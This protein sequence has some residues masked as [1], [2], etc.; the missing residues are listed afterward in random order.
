MIASCLGPTL[1]LVASS[2]PKL[3]SR[4][5][6][7]D[8][9][10]S[11]ERLL[12]VFEQPRWDATPFIELPVQALAP[13]AIEVVRPS[14]SVEIFAVYHWTIGEVEPCTKLSTEWLRDVGKAHIAAPIWSRG[15]PLYSQDLQR[16][17]ICFRW[18]VST[19]IVLSVVD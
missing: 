13:V 15:H 4:M 5:T 17:K 19:T 12:I 11:L 9:E 7:F 8:S 6:G 10:W 18:H 2:V 16:L 1:N 3:Y 14:A